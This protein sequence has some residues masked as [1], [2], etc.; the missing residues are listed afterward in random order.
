MF[1]RMTEER[2]DFIVACRMGNAHDYEIVEEPM[3]DDTIY[4]YVQGFERLGSI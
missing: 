3:A 4:N 2:L 1:E